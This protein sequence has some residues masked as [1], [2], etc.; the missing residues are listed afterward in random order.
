MS[1]TIYT[2]A[3]GHVYVYG[4]STIEVDDGWIEVTEG[5]MVKESPEVPPEVWNEKPVDAERAMQAV[6]AMSRSA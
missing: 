3:T 5:L 6:R 4:E 2:P 1:Y